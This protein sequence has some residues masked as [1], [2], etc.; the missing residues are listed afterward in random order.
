MLVGRGRNYQNFENFKPC[1]AYMHACIAA[2]AAYTMCDLVF[3]SS[4]QVDVHSFIYKTIN[5]SNSD[6]NFF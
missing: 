5:H 2:T 1:S 4:S 6:E 3:S